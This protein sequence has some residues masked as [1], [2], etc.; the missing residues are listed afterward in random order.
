[1]VAE[2]LEALIGARAIARA[3]ECR[4]VR[5]R[6]VEL[7]GILEA[8]ADALFERRAAAAAAAWLLLAVGSYTLGRGRPGD[9]HGDLCG[10]RFPA[11]RCGGFAFAATAHLTSVNIRL[12]RTSHGHR[13]ISQAWVPSLSEKKMICALPIIFS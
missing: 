7:R 5:Q 9:G 8:V 10:R 12:Q 1:M 13:Q 6:T 4:N 2:K 11:L 3:L